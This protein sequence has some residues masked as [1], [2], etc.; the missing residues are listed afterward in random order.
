MQQTSSLYR[1]ILS[2]NH[3]TETRVAIGDTGLL[4]TRQNE[5][6]T[7]GGTR[8]LVTASGADGGYDESVLQTAETTAQI[9]SGEQPTVGGCVSREI[10]VTML[11]PAGEIV[12]LSRMVPYIRL[13]DGERNSEWLQQG[14]FFI[15]SVDTDAESD[16]VQWVSIHGYDALMFAEQDYPENTKLS[17]PAK[18][19]D[20]VQEIASAIGVAVDARTI[21]L[22]TAA[23][24]I[25]YMPQYSCREILEYIAAL[26]A[27]CFIMSETGELQ[28][29]CFWGIPAETRYLIDNTGYAITFGG[30]RILV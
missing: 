20:V 17:W 13:T 18:D 14:V 4:I 22:M 28:L 15:D 27:G 5:Y 29:V 25:Q 1:E 12:G 21:A 3:W 2:G 7:F 11:K 6:I 10:D 9:F 8:I 30:D 23:Y 19:I 16:G 26:Y 24:L